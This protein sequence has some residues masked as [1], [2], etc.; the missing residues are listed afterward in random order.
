MQHMLKIKPS[1]QKTSGFTLVEMLVIAPIVILA[2]GGF[3]ALMVTMVGSVLA[4]RDQ[5]M[6]LY[7]SQDSLTR[8]ED[9][10][11][12][13][14][15]FLR[16]TG[17]VLTPQGSDSNFTGTA[18]FTNSS[19]TLVLLTLATTKNP[20]DST[21]ELVYY[22]NQPNACTNKIFNQ[23][24]FSQVVYFINNGSLWRRTILPPYNTNA[25]AD[26]E[27]LCDAP[28]QQN[29]C[30][31][32]Y[33]NARCKANDIE[34]MKNVTS[35][36]IKYY[37]TPTSTTDLGP[38]GAPDTSSVKVTV[39][40]SKT[41]A[42]RTV[43]TSQSTRATR[44]NVAVSPPT[45]PP[46]QF[47]GHPANA[48][49]IQTDTN[50]QFT[51]APSLAR[52]TLQWQRSTNGGSI[53][54]NI[55]GAT[56]ATYTL[57]T[58]S[59]SLNGYQYRAIASTPEESVI[60][61][62]ALLTVTLWGN[63]T[64]LNGYSRF[65][66]TA[67]NDLGY[68]KTARGVVM[69]KGMVK[70]SS[71]VVSG[72]VIAIL[73]PGKRPTGRLLFQTMSSGVAGRVDVYPN[74]EIRAVYGDMG[75]MTL[76]GITFIPAGGYAQTALTLV[77]GWTQYDPA[78]IAPGAFAT[79]SLGRVHIQG[80]VRPGTVTDNTQIA[81]NITA[82][83]SKYMHIPGRSDPRGAVGID[84]VSGVVAK[85]AANGHLSLQTM[86]YP[87]SFAGWSTFT[88]LNGWVSLDGGV[89][90]TTPGYAKG[91]DNIVRMK[92]LISSGNTAAGTIVGTLP[93]GYRPATR[94]LLPAL[95]NPNV[96]CRIDITPTGNVELYY[97]N[98]GWTSLDHV[99]FLAEQ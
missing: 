46:L 54:S 64:Y 87:S 48:T 59:T 17:T 84:P 13:S 73:P 9:D 28:W 89:S 7:E 33:V 75:W 32:G 91:D 71:A 49:V 95:C 70:K 55:A 5:T 45:M 50:I 53:W 38:T 29:S 31:P 8:V 58:V 42:G 78:N 34:L 3:I 72:E 86:Y 83:P 15:Q 36:D 19:S 56:S 25:T 39:N 68:T 51:A 11:R 16:T 44:L 63:L 40:G 10:I 41:V 47:T 92:G 30:S 20:A 52:A 43:A 1:D 35:M 26:F 93:A 88:L 96:E 74:G 61:N 79:D 2:L 81:S 99:T 77:N 57:S 23:V 67:Y 21:R 76:D 6:M 12:L 62:P 66:A 69:L 82:R 24:Y 18:A 65:D 37:A 94:V 14:A 98:A 4:T 90:F 97:S 60:S 22:K 27:S 80:L 85:G